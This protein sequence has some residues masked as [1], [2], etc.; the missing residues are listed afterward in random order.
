[1]CQTE[2]ELTQRF[3]TVRR[4]AT[5]SF[6]DARVYLERY[7][8]SARHIEVQIF[9][10]GKG[11][12]VALGERDCSLQRR[13]QKVVEE[14]PAPHLSRK[15][16]QTLRQ[17]AIA[18]GRAV[19]YA[20][21]GTVEFVYDVERD[22]VYFLEVNTR[23][24]VEHPVTEEVYGIDLIEW[25]IR[26][27]AGDFTLPAE[28]SLVARG[29]AIEARIYAEDPARDFRPS[30]GRLT[31]VRFSEI[32]RI[33]GWVETGSEVTPFY[34]P[35]LAKLIVAAPTRALA[36]EKLLEALGACA[37]SGIETN[38]AY[39]QAISRD[40]SFR[41]GRMTTASL[42]TLPYRPRSI[43]VI[44]AGAQSSLQD[45]PGRL[46]LWH[47]GVP[48]SG[49]MD[50]RSHR[51]V[52]RVLGNP[53]GAPTL[54]CTLLGPRL[55]FHCET[56]IALG[57]AGMSATLDGASLPFWEPISVRAGQVLALGR[58]SG[59]GQRLY[60]GVRHGFAAPQILGSRA[61]FALGGF[62]GHG[63]GILKP[64]DT[65]HINESG[66]G[67]AIPG[68]LPPEELPVL[69][70]AW[71]I[72]VRYGPHGAPDFF[73]EEDIAT[74][75]AA[76]YEVHFNSARTG[77]R[78]IGPRPRWARADGGEAGLHPSNIHDNAYAVGSLDFTGDMPIILGP[79]GPSLG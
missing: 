79:D 76:Q 15:T 23:L 24:Q 16:R 54:E 77:V 56:V 22:E 34:D 4:L 38:L 46:G 26:Q 75:F 49:P 64:G 53:E 36:I 63:A 39:L 43:E 44:E 5:G 67:D 74:L 42:K 3:E 30:A 78:L 17:A 58:I 19:S 28:A 13:H 20:S 68:R 11:G 70:D 37:L 8:A 7:V 10:D 1:L 73:L 50:D 51:L 6:G 47:V 65:L 9:G 2:A 62:G 35:L 69:T 52:N 59:P 71:E 55:R 61:T 12:V 27:A 14:T 33:D 48:P 66:A 45:W 32:A 18:L 41:A 57:G 29:H 60:L 25:M 31:E 21:A 72:G 40:P